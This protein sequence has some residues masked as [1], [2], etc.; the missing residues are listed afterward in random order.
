MGL[1]NLCDLRHVR[2]E[3]IQMYRQDGASFRRDNSFDLAYIDI[4]RFWVGVHEYW[5]SSRQPDRL[6]CCEKGIGGGNDLVAWAEA[7]SEKHEQQCIGTR[8]DSHGFPHVHVA[9]E[10]FLKLR[11]LRAEH[12]TAALQHFKDC[13][14][15][16]GLQV[17]VLLHMA[18]KSDA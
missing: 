17:V 6:C 3:A 5:R 12:I 18:I 9:G 7:Q 13:L 8:I 2:G 1:G 16:L 15:N 14:I 10:L 11:Q 4:A